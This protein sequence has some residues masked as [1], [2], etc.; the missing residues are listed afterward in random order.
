MQT[1]VTAVVAPVI[2]GL[3]LVALDQYRKFANVVEFFT[4]PK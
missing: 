1:L 4:T 3:V 2:L